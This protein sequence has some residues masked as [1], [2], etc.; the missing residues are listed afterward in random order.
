[1]SRLSLRR[2]PSSGGK[3]QLAREVRERLER[4]ADAPVHLRACLGSE[5]R[6]LLDHGERLVGLEITGAQAGGGLLELRPELDQRIGHA[7]E[8]TGR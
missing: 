4:R 3:R 2:A 1:M 8:V 5:L 6:T 7:S